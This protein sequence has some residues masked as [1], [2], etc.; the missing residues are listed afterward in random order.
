MT[1][2][3]DRGEL[4]APAAGLAA[5]S[6]IG[7]PARGLA[8]RSAST[9]RVHRE[10]S[11]FDVNSG[12]LAGMRRRSGGEPRI[13]ANS[14]GNDRKSRSGW[15][16]SIESS[17]TGRVEAFSDGVFA[18]VVTLL[19]FNLRVPPTIRAG[20]STG[21]RGCGRLTSAISRPLPTS[22]SSG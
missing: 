13:N 14:S 20:Y 5:R 3:V 15:R 4:P 9:I 8:E 19:V 12:M 18:V 16:P 11:L 21:W 6:V 1:F 22:G 2:H 7:T 17:D 10:H